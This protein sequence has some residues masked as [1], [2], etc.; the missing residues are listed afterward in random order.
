MDVR[1]LWKRRLASFA[2][3]A[4]GYSRYIANSGSI[5]FLIFAFIGG[6][7][8]YNQLL[9]SIPPDLPVEWGMA[10]LFAFLI[11]S[12]KIRTFIKEGDRVFVLPAEK[13]MGPYF[14]GAIGYSAIVQSIILFLL[15][16]LAWPLYRHCMG[17][18]TLPFLQVIF[19]LIVLKV[20]NILAVW[21]ELKIDHRGMKVFHKV[22]RMLVLVPILYFYFSWG[23]NFVLAGAIVAL[24]FVSL[25]YYRSIFGKRLLRWDD[26]IQEEKKAMSRFYRFMNGFIDVP[27]V[28]VSVH[29]RSWLSGIT[30]RLS[31]SQE[32]TYTYLILKSFI[33]SDLS[34]IILRMAILG[35]AVIIFIPGDLGKGTAYGIFLYLVGVQL[36]ALRQIHAHVF[37]FFLYPVDA[38]QRIEAIKRVNLWVLGVVSVLLAVPLF[39]TFQSVYLPVV[40]ILLALIMVVYLRK[41]TTF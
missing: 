37:W 13:D 21:Q 19:T 39:V 6:A 14:K 2:K 41:R 15:L 5:A 18:D 33:R 38:R 23:M 1:I 36:I 40:A 25:V 27:G 4:A 24:L 26:L 29:R 12:G 9:Q 8:Y 16:L 35:L 11:A 7:I 30:N 22:I 20:A 34:G 10:I 3:E 17:E 32:N 28:S 31:F